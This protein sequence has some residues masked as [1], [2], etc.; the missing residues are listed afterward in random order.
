MTTLKQVMATIKTYQEA[1]MAGIYNVQTSSFERE[2]DLRTKL[3]RAI[4][5][6]NPPLDPNSPEDLHKAGLLPQDTPLSP[7]AEAIY[8]KYKNFLRITFHISEDASSFDKP[9]IKNFQ[10]IRE[11][12]IKLRS[13]QD[14]KLKSEQLLKSWRPHELTAYHRLCVRL[15]RDN[16]LEV[17]VVMRDFE[18]LD[19]LILNEASIYLAERLFEALRS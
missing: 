1:Y 14:N 16:D 3:A 6:D 17:E 8:K 9:E 12:Y 11:L 19:N 7:V 4:A 5:R 13:Q 15:A 2:E 18:D 10:D